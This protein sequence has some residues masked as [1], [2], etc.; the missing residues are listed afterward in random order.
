MGL[1]CDHQI[2][3]NQESGVGRYDIVILPACKKKRGLL[4]ELKISKTEEKTQELSKKACQQILEK[5]YIEGLQRKGY[6]DIVGYGIAF[7]KK[8]CWITAV[9][10]IDN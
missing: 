8:S 2:C 1:F 7:Y 9:K 6:H 3:S 4:F 5:K 10:D